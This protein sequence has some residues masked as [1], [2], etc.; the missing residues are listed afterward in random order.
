M[1][2]IINFLHLAPLAAILIMLVAPK[3]ASL[4]VSKEKINAATLIL[5]SVGI[6]SGAIDHHH[7]EYLIDPCFGYVASLIVVAI[8]LMVVAP[9]QMKKI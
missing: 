2:Q 3:F 8:K 5:A 9:Q 4:L 1:E 6:L 7:H